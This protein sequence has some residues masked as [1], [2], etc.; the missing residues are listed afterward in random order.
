MLRDKLQAMVG[1]GWSRQKDGIEP[2]SAQ[3]S[4]R[5]GSFLDGKIG[6]QN[7]INAGV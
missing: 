4:H 3:A 2:L 5:I 7:A 6:K 1:A